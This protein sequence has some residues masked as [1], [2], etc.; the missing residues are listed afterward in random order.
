MIPRLKITYALRDL[1]RAWNAQQQRAKD[2][3]YAGPTR[4]CA[5][6]HCLNPGRIFCNGHGSQGR[7]VQ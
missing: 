4:W 1:F 3:Y 5:V 6:P 2:A 7:K